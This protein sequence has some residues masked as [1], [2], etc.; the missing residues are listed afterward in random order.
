[1]IVQFKKDHLV[2][3]GVPWD[4]RSWC[5]LSETHSRPAASFHSLAVVFRRISF[6]SLKSHTAAF[7]MKVQAHTWHSCLMSVLNVF[8]FHNFSKELRNSLPCS[9]RVGLS[10]ATG[11]DSC[12]VCALFYVSLVNEKDQ[13]LLLLSSQHSEAACPDSDSR[14]HTQDC[15][16]LRCWVI[17]FPVL[18]EANRRVFSSDK[19]RL[20]I[21]QM[22]KIN[23]VPFLHHFLDF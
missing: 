22:C 17:W 14:K 15:G 20:Y 21:L 19:L 23:C 3:K 7:L 16:S 11:F 9:S 4:M 10:W 13:L 2:T 6:D 18:F 12:D 1:M 8:F 5:F